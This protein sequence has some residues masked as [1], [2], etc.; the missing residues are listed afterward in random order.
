LQNDK[1]VWIKAIAG[2]VTL[3]D[4]TITGPIAGL[5]TQPIYIDVHLPAEQT[6]TQATPNAHNAFIYLYE[7]ELKLGNDSVPSHAAA[8]L[9]P[10]DAVTVT[11][12]IDAKF[13]LLAAAPLNEPVVQYGPFVM[14][15]RE[16]IEQAVSDYQSGKLTAA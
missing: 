1:G 14:N 3:S 2:T 6:F 15:T 8:L 5:T 13:I 10:G 12:T 11:A 9:G 4:Q 16:E 7:G